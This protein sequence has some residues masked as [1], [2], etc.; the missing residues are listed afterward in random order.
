MCFAFALALLAPAAALEVISV[1]DDVNAVSLSDVVEVVPGQEGRV[2]LSTAPGEDG[3][4]RRIEVLASEQG[5]NPSY[6]LFALRND[7]D[8]QIERLLVAPF[9]RLPGSGIIQP[10]LGDDRVSALTPSAGIRPVRL[11]DSEADVF[12]VTLDPGATVTFV[13]E[14]RGASLPE[15]YLWQPNAYRDY[16]NSFTL[17]R[18]VVLGVASLAAVF[19]T[20]MFVVK[21]R[22]VFPATA[23]FAWAVM[24]YL[25][26]DFG[27]MGR[28]LGLSAS[29]VQP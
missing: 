17:F 20:I 13:A 21:G 4:I 19:L 29:G 5:T 10:D 1:P 2:Q 7:S 14:L 22:G 28:L 27:L 3:I 12:E 23:A 15:L 9:F 25:L 11:T 24:A 8:Q 18:G 6:G 26:I 16:V